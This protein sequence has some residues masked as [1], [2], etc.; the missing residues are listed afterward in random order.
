LRVFWSSCLS[1]VFLKH[2][3]EQMAMERPGSAA[4]QAR[5]RP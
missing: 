4:W 1:C 2:W 5:A 3:L